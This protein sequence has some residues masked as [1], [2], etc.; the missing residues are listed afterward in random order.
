MDK[1]DGIMEDHSKHPSKQQRREQERIPHNN[2]CHVNYTQH[3]KRE[4]CT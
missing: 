2:N 4:Q 1:E 3:R